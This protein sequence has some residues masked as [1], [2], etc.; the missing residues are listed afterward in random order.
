MTLALSVLVVAGSTPAAAQTE[1]DSCTTID[2]SGS[3][4]LNQ[5][6]TQ[7]VDS[8]CI[9]IRADDV[10]FDGG[11]HT[12]DYPG[13]L[14]SPTGIDVDNGTGGLSNVTVR[15]VRVEGFFFGVQYRRVEDGRIV[16]VETAN[17]DNAMFVFE[18]RNTTVR[19]ATTESIINVDGP[20]HLVTGSTVTGSSD[21][22]STGI[23]ADSN[24]T[25]RHSAVRK[26][27]TG[28]F[29]SGTGATFRNNTVVDSVGY[30]VRLGGELAA[31]DALVEDSTIRNSGSDGVFVGGLSANRNVTI[32][33]GEVSGSRGDGINVTNAGT[34]PDATTVE[35]VVVTDN[36]GDGVHLGDG[37]VD[38]TL[39]NVTLRSNDVDGFNTSGTTNDTLLVDSTVGANGDDAV[40][41]AGS[42]NVTGRAVDVGGVTT[43]FEAAHVNFSA[44]DPASAP[45]TPAN[46][47]GLGAYVAAASTG[48]ASHLNL[49]VRY[50]ASD[51]SGLNESTVTFWSYDG[52]TWSESGGTLDTASNTIRYN[53]TSFST[54]APLAATPP[55]FETSVRSAPDAVTAGDAVTV[56]AAVNN[57]GGSVDT[58]TV[59]LSVDGTQV[60]SASVS[61]A[62][63]GNT[64]VDLSWAT[65][66]DNAG[67]RSLTVATADDAAST[68]VTVE[69]LDMGGG[70]GGSALS[71][72]TTNLDPAVTNA[73]VVADVELSVSG[74][75]EGTASVAEVDSFPADVESPPGATVAGL[76]VSVPESATDADA[77]LRITVD[78]SAVGP[79]RRPESL[80]VHRYDGSWRAVPTSVVRTSPDRIVLA[81]DLDGFSY[82]AVTAPATSST[83]T[84]TPTPTRTPTA[85]RTATP[86]P[87]PDASTA[88]LTSTRTPTPT[89]GS[90]PGFGG[91]LAAAAVLVVGW[92]AARRD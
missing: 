42:S 89:S 69:E 79:D 92:V 70:G 45:A 4:L 62:G 15:D 64:T 81:A 10:T 1:I 46:R 82:F 5:S 83:A 14:G 24:A 50:A 32:R 74:V 13:D 40:D 27:G 38:T 29:A 36:A 28:L 66:G 78:R 73:E 90:G 68:T 25:V 49:T 86:T 60:D 30:G 7:S 63:G 85:T 23:T 17:N 91:A 34:G 19:N 43:D 61:L 80:D 35:D 39:R 44:V 31:E 65:E 22:L 47:V 52:G 56:T 12:I 58:R 48:S 53:F 9:V 76:D 33:G 18:G 88:T 20:D 72:A 77:T 2:S 87:T 71:T 67:D 75:V 37:V 55:R 6:V 26:M 84:A 8:S 11:G 59:T 41:A 16:D 54:L 3:Y 21:P 51:V 57:T